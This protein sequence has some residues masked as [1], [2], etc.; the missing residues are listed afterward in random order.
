[1]MHQQ[2]VYSAVASGDGA[3]LREHLE[4]RPESVHEHDRDGCT[5][6]LV[7]ARDGH[8]E[9]VKV[10]VER[11]ADIEARDPLYKRSPLAWATFHAHPDVAEFLLKNGADANASDAYGNTPLKTATMGRQGAW[12][13]WVSC[14]PHDYETLVGLLRAHGATERHDLKGD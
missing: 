13:E 10:L 9:A 4:T 1:M 8:L 2:E 11:G 6:L 3:R 7:A 12:D 5:P 14:S